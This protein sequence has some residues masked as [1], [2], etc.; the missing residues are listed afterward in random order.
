MKGGRGSCKSM[1][2]VSFLIDES[3]DYKLS[4][5]LF[6]FS[7]EIQAT[8][9]DGLY[10]MCK[11]LIDQAF[12]TPYFRITNNRIVNKLTGVEFGFIGLRATGGKTAFSQVNKIKGKFKVKYLLVDEAQD[13]TEETI[14]VLFPTVNRSSTVSI[15]PKPW[16]TQK[17]DSIVNTET[18]FLFAMNPNYEVDPILEKLKGFQHA[19]MQKKER[20]QVAIIH[21]NIFDVPVEFQDDQLLAEAENEENQVYYDHVWLG[22][23]SYQIGGFPFSDTPTITMDGGDV[24]ILGAFLDPSGNGRDRTA[25]SFVGKCSGRLICWGKTW[26]SAWNRVIDDIIV[27]LK[28][29]PPD[30]FWYEDNGVQ[31]TGRQMFAEKGMDAIPYCTHGNKEDRIYSVAAV[32][33]NR[34]SI[35]ANLCNSEYISQVQKYNEN[36]VFDDAPD[37]LAS[38]LIKTGII[39]KRI[40][41]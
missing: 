19:A 31:D 1:N 37:S 8:I 2:A 18:R 26:R 30:Y 6:L 27:E 25:L 22:E 29:T 14:N 23:S 34:I 21:R 32:I 16:H 7:R 10:S 35:V 38:C 24:R 41:F 40:K 17:D 5:S 20:S 3:F 15:V 9:A 36:A 39:P 28:K 13:L 11:S 33:S 12:L 4:G